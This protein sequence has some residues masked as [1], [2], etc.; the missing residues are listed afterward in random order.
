[1][2][3]TTMGHLVATLFA[4]YERSYGDTEI[5]ALATHAE[6]DR[7]GVGHRNQTVGM[8]E[9]SAAARVASFDAWERAS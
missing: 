3:K 4:K 7:L 2:T 9:A 6:L 8:R 1:M 5:A